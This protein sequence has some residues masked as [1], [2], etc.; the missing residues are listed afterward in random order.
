MMFARLLEYGCWNT[1]AGI[2]WER[3]RSVGPLWGSVQWQRTERTGF[4]PADQFYPVASLAMKCFRPLS[5]LSRWLHSPTKSSHGNSQ[6][7]V[8]RPG[9]VSISPAGSVYLTNFDRFLQHGST[10]FLTIGKQAAP[11]CWNSRQSVAIT[12]TCPATRERFWVLY[13]EAVNT[14]GLRFTQ[15]EPTAR[16]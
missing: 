15:R 10:N 2:S 5:H 9:G 12:P 1:V 11:N 14:I 16:A 6:L 13:T 7:G 3:N 4:E 8:E